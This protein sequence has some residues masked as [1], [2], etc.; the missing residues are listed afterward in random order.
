MELEH[1]WEMIQHPIF[2]KAAKNLYWIAWVADTLENWEHC[3]CFL[4]KLDKIDIEV[5]FFKST[6][7]VIVKGNLRAALWAL[8]QHERFM[9]RLW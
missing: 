9:A 8:S 7:K 6:Y 5:F 4:L 2:H 3:V 1:F